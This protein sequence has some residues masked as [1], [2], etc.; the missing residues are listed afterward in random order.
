MTTVKAS[1]ALLWVDIETTGLDEWAT[2]AMILEI[3]FVTTDAKGNILESR[4][5][6]PA[7]PRNLLVHVL[8]NM[9]EYCTEMHRKSGLI[10]KLDSIATE[11][12]LQVDVERRAIPH[13]EWMQTL[14]AITCHSLQKSILDEILPWLG[15]ERNHKLYMAGASVHFDRRWM[16]R[17]LPNVEK[18]FH[19]RD[20]D[21]STIRKAVEMVRPDLAACE[22]ARGGIHRAEPDI[23][24]ALYYF[25]WAREY[26]FQG[27][28][29]GG[30][31]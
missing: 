10:D 8:N 19:Y 28:T 27:G 20:F 3:H 31:S 14:C 15:L 18:G 5:I 11:S 22:P 13:E 23:M 6:V 25:G 9:D 30:S 2:G 24:E 26:F 21:I 29:D 1:P 17:F 7:M 12:I 4:G 16:A